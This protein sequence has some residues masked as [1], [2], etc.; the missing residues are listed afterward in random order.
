M[1]GR[2]GYLSAQ[3]LVSGIGAFSGGV[4]LGTSLSVFAETLRLLS[5]S[6]PRDPARKVSQ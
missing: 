4:W 6:E 2:C 3:T 1:A 5:T